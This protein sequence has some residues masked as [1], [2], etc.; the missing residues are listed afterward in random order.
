MISEKFRRQ[1]RQ[2]SEKWWSEGLID[3]ALYER[4]AAR[5]QFNQLEGDASHR[6]VTILMGLG[7][8][9]LG[10]GAITFVAANW[11]EWS[12]SLKMLLL[13][14]AFVGVNAA[15]FYL[16]RKPTSQK[17]QQ[18]LGHGLLLLGALLLGA[19]LGLMSQMFHQSGDAYEL[20]L[21]W[22]LG[23][24]AMAYSLRLASL[25]VLSLILVAIAYLFSWSSSVVWD[26]FTGTSLIIQHLPLVISLVFVPLAYW[27]RRSRVIVGLSAIAIA[28]SFVFNF[29][30]YAVWSMG[31]IIAIAFV[32]PPALLWS[33]SEEIWQRRPVGR[34]PSATR[35]HARSFQPISRSL[36]T[37]FLSVVFYAFAFHYWWLTNPTESTYWI[38]VWNWY[39]LIDAAGLG[40]VAGLGW[41]QLRYQIRFGR[42]QERAVNSGLIAI[43]LI[44][45]A[46]LF[47]WH[48]QLGQVC[49]LAFNVMLFVFAIALIRDG[50]ALTERHTFWGGT[51]LL[52]LSIISRSLEYNTGLL[53]KSIVLALCGAGV[54]AAGLWFERKIQPHRPQSLPRS[55]EELP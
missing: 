29:K 5:Y 19:N 20:F 38:N 35:A 50:L 54:I 55:Q 49:A 6:F 12:R 34:L 51:V 44:L 10:L 48:P 14:S 18:R 23:V 11:Q 31:W 3:A 52:V 33:Y 13:I 53:L 41:L 43:L 45:T 40:I 4:L 15:G 17:G 46:M 22:G 9:L 27:C 21:V 36:A 8:V 39:P 26:Q 1:L 16:W 37:V 25:G 7:A 30:F 2:E 28:I 32:L 24:A 47:T 42:L